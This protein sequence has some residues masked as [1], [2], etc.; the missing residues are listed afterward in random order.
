MSHKILDLICIGRAGVDLYGEQVGGRLEDMGSF[1]KY[2]GGSPSNTAIGTARLGLKSAMLTRVGDEHMGRFIRETMEAEGVD[3]QQI[4]T[5]P[6][7][8]TALVL[9]GIQDEDRFPLIFYRE[10]CADMALCETDVNPDFI[11]QA[12]AVLVSG[13]H[14]S[15]ASVAAASHKAMKLARANGGRVALDIDY[16]PNLWNLAGHGE[17]ESRFVADQGVSQH[18]Q[19]YLADCDLIVGT[20]EE[21]H[22]AGGSED[23]LTALSRVRELTEA[24]LVCKRGAKGCKV[25]EAAINGW[26]SGISG[27][28]FKV[29]VFNV[30]GAGDAFMAGLL[31]GW[32][33]DEDWQTSCAYANACGAFAVSRHGCCPAYPSE[34][35]LFDF[36]EHG[37]EYEALRFDTELN[38]LHRATTRRKKYDRV[39]AFACDHRHQ[40][41]TWA[42]EHGRE[43][44]AIGQFKNLAWQAA[45]EEAGDDSGF[46]VLIDDQLGRSALH[47]ATSSGAWVGRPIESSGKFPLEFE[48]E[49]EIT[50]HLADWPLTQ[51]VKVL[52]PYRLDDDEETRAHHEQMIQRLYR[53]CQHTGHEWLLEIITA[54]N[55][56]IPDFDSVATIM[57]RF[58]ELGVK[59]DWWKLEPGKDENYWQ[60]LGRVIDDNDPHCQG[61]IVLGLDG[62][63]ESISQSFMLAA[64]QSWVKGF[65]VGRTLFSESAKAWLAGNIDDAAAVKEMRA[66]FR[67]MIGAWDAACT[68]AGR[69]N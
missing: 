54:R 1:A 57:R 69:L 66:K 53:A 27:P 2:V 63:I 5:D 11:A 47:T 42:S 49:G 12:K 46:G 34:T 52:C 14:L 13:T 43:S 62:T 35:E 19:N 7:R 29:E 38:H 41:E 56:S 22:I 40:F 6:Q 24:T 60:N 18:L 23:T 37:S 50:E 8:L 36:I 51:T 48:A 20:E 17:G 9:L 39:V 65:A 28:G 32:L 25:F 55:G 61:I 45:S 16:R 33:R 15:T 26:E 58:Y 21:F 64:A 68:K 4:I 44:T 59:P 3:T 30:L 67:S 31:R 10:N